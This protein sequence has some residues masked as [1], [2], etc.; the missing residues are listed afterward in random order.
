MQQCF[1]TGGLCLLCLH[2]LYQPESHFH[3]ILKEGHAIGNHLRAISKIEKN[4]NLMAVT[5]F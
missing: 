5:V 4:T 1:L 2:F 3:Q